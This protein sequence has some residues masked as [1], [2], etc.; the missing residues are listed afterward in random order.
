MCGQIILTFRDSHSRA[1]IVRGL[2][3]PEANGLCIAEIYGADGV[4]LLV[5]RY[6][7]RLT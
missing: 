5:K 1:Q 7:S 3:L 6:I 4:L 2:E